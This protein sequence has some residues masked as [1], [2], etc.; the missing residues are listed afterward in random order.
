MRRPL[1]LKRR[2]AVSMLASWPLC[3]LAGPANGASSAELRQ[4]EALTG[5][6][7]TD[8]HGSVHAL[9]EL[10]RPLVLV[11]LWSSWCVGCRTELPTIRELASRLGADAL[12]VVLLSHDLYWRDDTAYARENQL[13]FPNW[14]LSART[15]ETGV[16]AAFR[17]E[18]DSFALPQSVVFAGRDRALVW[19][20]EGSMDWTASNT[21]RL[22]RTWLAR[23]G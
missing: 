4:A 20:Q 8:T 19:S 22:I 6:E 14:R 17:M 13:P 7:F 18:A 11:Y 2:T 12:D 9:S 15:A 16:G 5:A 10:S 1:C 23:A 3:T 21:L